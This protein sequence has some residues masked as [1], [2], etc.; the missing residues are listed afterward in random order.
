MKHCLVRL[1]TCPRPFQDFI[2]TDGFLS[3]GRTRITCT[4]LE[5]WHHGGPSLRSHLFHCSLLYA[6]PPELKVSQF[7]EKRF[8]PTIRMTLSKVVNRGHTYV[9]AQASYTGCQ[10]SMSRVSLRI[11]PGHHLCL[12]LFHLEGWSAKVGLVLSIQRFAAR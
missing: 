2:G 12:P 6:G 9:P 11:D 5:G 8:V 4:F 1:V 3:T 7:D 10:T